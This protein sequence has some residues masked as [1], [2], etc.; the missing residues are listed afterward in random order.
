MRRFGGKQKVG[1]ERERERER[2][3]KN[4]GVRE[5][6]KKPRIFQM[7]GDAR[8]DGS[9]RREQRS[10]GLRCYV[11][12]ESEYL[13]D[14]FKQLWLFLFFFFSPNSYADKV[15]KDLWGRRRHRDVHIHLLG[16]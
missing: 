9:F 10:D 7:N 3:G 15:S 2:E 6:K 13:A 5:T 8:D 12:S 14:F 1:H 4:G 11:V 16:D